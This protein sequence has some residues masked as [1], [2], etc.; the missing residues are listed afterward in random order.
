MTLVMTS[1]PS[2]P[3]R[4]LTALNFHQ[5]FAAST[6]LA[7]L[8]VD[9]G[10]SLQWTATSLRFLLLMALAITKFRYGNITQLRTSGLCPL[11]Y[12]EAS[13]SMSTGLP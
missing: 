1:E 6:D 3:I 7:V 12:Q 9:L 11:R 13:L 8:I 5:V 4:W 10:K 2:S